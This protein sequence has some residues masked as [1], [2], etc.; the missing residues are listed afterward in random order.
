MKRLVIHLLVRGYQR[1]SHSEQETKIRLKEKEEEE[2]MMMRWKKKVRRLVVHH[3]V[4]CRVIF[5]SFFS[6][7]LIPSSPLQT[8]GPSLQHLNKNRPRPVRHH[9]RKPAALRQQANDLPD[10]VWDKPTN[11]I[12]EPDSKDERVLK[13]KTPEPIKPILPEPV[14]NT[15]TVKLETRK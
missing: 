4:A 9:R 7:V 2:E 8:D 15:E 1:Y 5:E 11:G 14:K 10:S 12:E 6:S 3:F 13:P